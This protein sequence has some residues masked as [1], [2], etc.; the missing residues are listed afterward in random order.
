MFKAI[1]SFQNKMTPKKTPQ[2]RF[3][4]YFRSK[5]AQAVFSSANKVFLPVYVVASSCLYLSEDCWNL[6]VGMRYSLSGSLERFQITLHTCVDHNAPLCIWK[7]A[8]FSLFCFIA[9][10]LSHCNSCNGGAVFWTA[11]YGTCDIRLNKKHL[12]IKVMRV[13]QGFP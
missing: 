1:H 5:L 7:I 11:S 2:L 12:H 4:S 3:F 8:S 13:L 6:H 9:L 10:V